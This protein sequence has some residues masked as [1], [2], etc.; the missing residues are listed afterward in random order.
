MDYELETHQNKLSG[1]RFKF[2]NNDCNVEYFAIIREESNKKK[3]EKNKNLLGKFYK[4]MNI[5]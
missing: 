1:L 4:M 3:K 5:F 2:K